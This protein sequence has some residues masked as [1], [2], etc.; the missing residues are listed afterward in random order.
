MERTL[1]FSNLTENSAVFARP[2]IKDGIV[3]LG[4]CEKYFYAIDLFSGHKLWSYKAGGII[5][6]SAA[7]HE[8]VIYVGSLDTY[9]YAF[10]REGHVLWT[11]KSDGMI[12]GSPTVCGNTIYFGSCD[13][14]LYA[15]SLKTRKLLWRFRAGD[16]IVSD[17][18]VDGERIFFGSQ[19]GYMYCVGHGGNLIWKF[20]SGGAILLGRPAASGNL[21]FFASG[22]QNLYAVKKEDGSFAWGFRTGDM[23]F[24]HPI[25][26]GDLVCLGS[27]DRY[28][29]AL[30]KSTGAIAWKFCT[31]DRITCSAAL[32]RETVIFGTNKIYAFDKTGNM[33][34]SYPISSHYCSDG[35]EVSE[36][37]VVSGSEDGFIFALDARTGKRIWKFRTNSTAPLSPKGVLPPPKWDSTLFEKMEGIGA[38]KEPREPYTFTTLLDSFGIEARDRKEYVTEDS[39]A[40]N[41]YRAASEH[42]I[43]G[44]DSPQDKK[45]REELIKITRTLLGN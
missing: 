5:A 8:G 44:G 33:V 37:I 13:N 20:K 12:A 41:Q 22:D 36:D 3:Y 39:I 18:L 34:W 9:L 42:G 1:N 35:L 32:Y 40:K 14:N 17:V 15:I 30:D 11:F 26:F 43:Y 21:L 45:K 24:N 6:G 2:L 31:T 7:M 23:A 4:A 19:D 10:S 25:V 38:K 27:R 16:E 28:F 29:Y